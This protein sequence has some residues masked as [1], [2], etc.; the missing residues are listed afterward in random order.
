MMPQP[1]SAVRLTQNLPHSQ[2]SQTIVSQS[3]FST[4]GEDWQ[5]PVCIFSYTKLGQ[6][7]PSD[8]FVGCDRAGL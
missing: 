4:Q 7:C 5:I 3:S 6:L 2:H 8:H 1:T